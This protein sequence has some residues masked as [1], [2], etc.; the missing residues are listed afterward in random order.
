MSEKKEFVPFNDHTPVDLW[1]D[2]YDTDNLVRRHKE[3]AQF[4]H[5]A[6]ISYY[7]SREIIEKLVKELEE[8][9]QWHKHETTMLRE[10]ELKSIADKLSDAYAFLNK[11]VNP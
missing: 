11:N 1:R 6:V 4:A 10:R 8:I 9:L 2:E 7:P 5:E 3:D